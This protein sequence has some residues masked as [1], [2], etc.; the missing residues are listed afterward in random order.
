MKNLNLFSLIFI[1]TLL[2]SC[3]KDINVTKSF[4]SKEVSSYDHKVVSDWID[5][6]LQIDKN[7]EGFRHGPS[8][9]A[10]AYAGL[11]AYES[12]VHG[13]PEF[14]TFDGYWS[15]FVMPTLDETKDYCWP[16]A[17]NAS[18]EYLLP[19]LYG[20]AK[21]EELDLISSTAQ[22]IYNIYNQTVTA[23]VANNSKAWG[24]SVAEA[25]WN[26]SKT[27]PIGHEYYI[28]PTKDYDW[29]QAYTKEGDWKPTF[30]NFEL[31]IGGTWGNART[32]A[33]KEG[34][35][36]CRPPMPY[37]NIAGANYYIQNLE[38]MAQT[39]PPL[40]GN[41]LDYNTLF[42]GDDFEGFTFG[43]GLR[44]L[45]IG[46]QV[47]KLQNSNLSDAVYMTA[48]L[49]LTANDASV[50]SWYSKY[51]YNTE[52]PVTYIHKYIDPTWE[53]TFFSPITNQKGI[54]PAYPRYPSGHGVAHSAGSDILSL[55]FGHTYQLSDKSHAN[56]PLFDNDRPL[57]TFYELALEYTWSRTIH[58]INLR[59][60]L[61]EGVRFGSQISS[62]IIKLP[63][64]KK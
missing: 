28:N 14:N 21:S 15:G 56:I 29:Q 13:M 19:R 4:Q 11:S 7:A 34:S 64:K 45:S 38:V 9:R 62:D 12:A 32:F 16:L 51:H 61:E 17:I 40:S 47:L 54:T 41:P 42:S 50:A 39:T 48:L 35:K 57:R 60:D 59:Q 33:V 55:L 6:L 18:Y 22:K 23:E 5:I 3:D 63:W 49:G 53:P 31:P 52:N 46:N 27:D 20:N 44:F 58:G 36:L 2:I 26:Y 1:M 43:Y 24:I 10:L 30:P 8:A 25:V 37:S